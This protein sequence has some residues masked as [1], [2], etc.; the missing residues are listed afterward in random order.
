MKWHLRGGRV[1]DPEAGLDARADLWIAEGRIVAV[2]TPPADFTPDRTL[3]LDGLLVLPGL[4]D[5]SARLREPGLEHKATIASELPAAA[6][7]GITTLVCPPDTLPVVDS[8]AQI[9]H[10]QRNAA[11]VAGPRVEVL[12]A[13]TPGLRGEGLSEMAALRAAGC[14][15][16]SNGLR[17]L[18]NTLILRR[19]LEYAD[20]VGLAVHLHPI[21]PYLSAGGCAHEGAVATR[22]GLP[23]IPPAAE[24]AALAQIL[25]LVEQTGARVHLCRLS[26]E[27]GV[28]LVAQA[29]RD[30]L[31][32]TADVAMH[33]LLLTEA[34]LEGFDTHCHV[35]PPLRTER[36][37]RA[38]VEA[39]ATGEI[40]A[41][42][43]DHQPHDADAKNA[44]FP[45]T[46]PGASALD[47][48]LALGLQ[49]AARGELEL[50]T[51]V[52]RLTTGPARVLGIERGTLQVGH[53]AD[54][55]VV[56]LHRVWT[57]APETL[58]SQGK[59]TP[60]LGR[61][62]QGAVVHTWV[63]GRLVHSLETGD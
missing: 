16:L 35:L 29:R 15:G 3:S 52:A 49:L 40:Q 21:D 63:D 31:P 10:I 23:G 44:P 25:A 54:L 6:G 53:P 19:A 55:C 9:E 18:A 11:A 48:L 5:L 4:V 37:R 8:P 7:G 32:V 34:D 38:L 57:V 13:L 14:I 30:G 22:L 42:C 27:R 47:T 2:G 39:V 17:P 36:D 12:A 60:F 46:E 58:R 59:N 41:I 50:D 26:T 51:V 24:T 45:Q 56:D 43:S 33:Q 28:R 20:T 61:R 1:L 62:M